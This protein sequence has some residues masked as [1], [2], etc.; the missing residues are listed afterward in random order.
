MKVTVNIL[1]KFFTTCV[2]TVTFTLHT[3][4]PSYNSMAVFIVYM[5]KKNIYYMVLHI[6]KCNYK[7]QN[8]VCLFTT[9]MHPI[10]EKLETCPTKAIYFG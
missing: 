10:Q 6:T 5:F 4:K 3:S 7:K 2:S 1:L 9:M 8:N